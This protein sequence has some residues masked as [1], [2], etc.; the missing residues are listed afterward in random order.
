MG[1]IRERSSWKDKPLDDLLASKFL[2]SIIIGKLY[3]LGPNCNIDGELDMSIRFTELEGYNVQLMSKCRR[4]LKST[5]NKYKRRGLLGKGG[6]TTLPNPLN[7]FIL[8]K[9]GKPTKW[10][11]I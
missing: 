4:M 6:V 10:M 8:Y 2:R 7:E 3:F 11:M 9:G 1:R 5:I